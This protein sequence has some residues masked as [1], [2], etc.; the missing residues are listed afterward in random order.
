MN[1]GDK[2]TVP[3]PKWDENKFYL[4]GEIIEEVNQLCLD[5]SNFQYYWVKTENNKM[6]KY[7]KDEISK[8]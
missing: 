3:N 6:E 8:S 4:K 1:K 5:G 2:V 7:I